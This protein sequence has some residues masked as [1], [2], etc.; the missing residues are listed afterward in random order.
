[1]RVVE[2]STVAK[3]GS[4]EGGEDGIVLGAHFAGVVDGATDKS[5]RR[6]AG[7]SG[8]RF[9][10]LTLKDAVL[11][12]PSGAT[13]R[14]AVDLLST[15]VADAL[16]PGLP[17][18][19][20]PSAALTLFSRTR[21]EIWQVGDVGFGFPGAPA[22][23]GQKKVDRINV[24]M[25][26]AVLR[27]ELLRGASADELA[28]EDP[29]RAAIMP[30]LTRQVH[31]A[32]A[33]PERAGGLAYGTL[34]GRRVPDGLIRVTTLPAGVH[35]L[36]IGSDGYPELLGTLSESE[37]NLKILLADDPLCIAGLA[38]TKGVAPGNESYDDR[39]YLRLEL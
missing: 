32:N 8:G 16:P 30:L 12:L 1:M 37:R 31:F 21:R 28:A 29:G 4:P 39:T 10:M 7:V 2:S 11:D 26:A 27:A 23:P 33:D 38:G 24:E 3:N 9:V 17:E 20:R 5:G 13:A 19:D 25:R 6:F 34:D 36:I 14:E 22:P 35:E 18:L 15:A